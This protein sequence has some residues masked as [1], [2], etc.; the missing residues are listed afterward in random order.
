AR[1]VAQLP[2]A[3]SSSPWVLVA[4]AV[5]AT[6]VLGLR[7]LPTW[8]RRVPLTALVAATFIG[9]A[10]WLTLPRHGSSPPAGL[11]VTFL[12]VGQGDAELLEVKEG[13]V[14]VDTGPPEGKA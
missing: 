8:R 4:I 11:R 14:L 5:I 12:D 13:A 9:L 2:F 1:F 10:W 6:A 3:S 7:A